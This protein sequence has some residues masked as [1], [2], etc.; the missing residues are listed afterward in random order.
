M[1]NVKELRTQLTLLYEDLKN[2]KVEIEKAKVMVSAGNSIIKS[3]Q[4]EFDYIRF[5]KSKKE[6]TFL[7]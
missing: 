2:D 7:K 6:I 3:T 5:S 1:K 4:I